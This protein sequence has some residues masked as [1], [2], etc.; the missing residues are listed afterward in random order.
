MWLIQA[1]LNICGNFDLDLDYDPPETS[2][3]NTQ[4]QAL[5]T[6]VPSFNF[7]I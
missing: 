7:D 2:L 3:G 6:N 1:S 5:E 4:T